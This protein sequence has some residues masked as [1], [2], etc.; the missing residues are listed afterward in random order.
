MRNVADK[1]K[2]ETTEFT[3]ICVRND[4]GAWARLLWEE[5]GRVIIL[6]DFGHWSHWWG[7]RGEKT[8]A[9]FMADLDIGYMGS[10]MLGANRDEYSRESTVQAIREHIIDYRREWG[11][12][13]KEFARSEWDLSQQLLDGDLDFRMWYEQTKFDD[14]YEF[15]R[16][17]I[18]HR[19]QGFWDSLWVPLIQPALQNA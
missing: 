18:C 9:E 12:Y 19:W 8:V 3:E 5:H 7:H 6:S 14:A 11:T 1:I 4:H 16:T 13:S 10:K 17:E 2:T 15:N